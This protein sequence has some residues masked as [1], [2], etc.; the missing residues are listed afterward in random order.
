[1]T[2]CSDSEIAACYSQE[3]SPSYN[4]VGSEGDHHVAAA[5]DGGGQCRPAEALGV[6]GV[7][8]LHIIAAAAT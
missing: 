3:A 4:A 7:S 8:H 2:C 5:G 6:G 1:M